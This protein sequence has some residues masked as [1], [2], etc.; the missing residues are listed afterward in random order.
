L[1]V[2]PPPLPAPSPPGSPPAW[3]VILGEAFQA[4]RA[5]EGIARELAFLTA[6]PAVGALATRLAARASRD[7]EEVRRLYLRYS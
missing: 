6:D 2:L 3:G 1:G 7:G 4:E 5:L